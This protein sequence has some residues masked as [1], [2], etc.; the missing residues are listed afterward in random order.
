MAY[1]IPPRPEK[2]SK[3]LRPAPKEDCT[4]IGGSG[5]DIQFYNYLIIGITCAFVFSGI[6]LL[7][8]SGR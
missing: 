1:Y 5:N 6:V 3:R 8:T 4:S 7:F 2:E